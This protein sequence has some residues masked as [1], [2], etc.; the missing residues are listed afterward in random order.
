MKLIAARVNI[1]V[2]VKDEATKSEIADAI[3][4]VLT[5]HLEAG[6]YI[7]TWGYAQDE[8]TGLFYYGEPVDAE[9]VDDLLQHDEFPPMTGTTFD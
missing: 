7:V 6:G 3:S 8:H 4:T 5:D 9:Y 2:A 1:A